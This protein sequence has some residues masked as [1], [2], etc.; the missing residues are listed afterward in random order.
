ML[1]V[2]NFGNSNAVSSEG[3]LSSAVGSENVEIVVVVWKL[4]SRKVV[5]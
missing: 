5:A 3:G 4:A 1:V 2:I